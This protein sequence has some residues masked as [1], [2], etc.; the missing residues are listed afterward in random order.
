LSFNKV[1]A[2]AVATAPLRH[3]DEPI[4]EVPEVSASRIMRRGGVAAFKQ[5]STLFRSE[6]FTQ[7]P[8]VWQCIS[9][10]LVQTYPPGNDV[11]TGD[12]RLAAES[13]QNFLDTLT[14]LRDILPTLDPAL[15]SHINT[16][17]PS[18]LLGLQSRYAVVR[19]AVAKCFA[20]ASNIMTEV[21]ML[22]LVEQI[23]PLVD[24][25]ALENRQ[26]A[27]ELLFRE[28]SPCN[29]AKQEADP[30]QMLLIL[31]KSRRSHM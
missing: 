20:V 3:K 2:G 31:Y 16:L 7:L 17:F 5:L 11:K 1:I 28:L 21:A 30:L 9:E 15:L 8:K 24:D 6:L 19:Q 18:L 27:I 26:G 23:I 29:Y 12:N 25:A 13:G 22:F 10:E 4:T 14:A